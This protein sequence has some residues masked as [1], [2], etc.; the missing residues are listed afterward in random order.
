MAQP[1]LIISMERSQGP[2][3]TTEPSASESASSGIIDGRL[4][5]SMTTRRKIVTALETLIRAGT[6]SPT[7][8][9]VAVQ[10][11]VGL[12]TVFRH[13]DDMETLYREISVDL[14]AISIPLLKTRLQSATWQSRLMESIELRAQI[15]EELTPFFL[16]SSLHRHQS[17]FLQEQAIRSAQSQRGVL[18]KILP[19]HIRSE[20]WL[21]DAL[22]L[23]LSFDA[24]VRLRREQGLTRK[25]AMLVMQRGAQSLLAACASN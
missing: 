5:R 11:Q 10:A 16:S 19:D 17:V 3:R 9:Q 2:S 7:A 14:D 24:W 21:V 23:M 15:F 1:S 22:D 8:E 20:R 6:L 18:E 4:H 25:E 12:R 13:F